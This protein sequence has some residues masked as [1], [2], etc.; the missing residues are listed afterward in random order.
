MGKSRYLFLVLI[1]ALTTVDRLFTYTGLS[2]VVSHCFLICGFG[3]WRWVSVRFD[4]ERKQ[5]GEQQR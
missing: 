1:L 4:K 3:G 2:C 5:E